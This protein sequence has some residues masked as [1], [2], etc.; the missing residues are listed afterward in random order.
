MQKKQTIAIAVVIVVLLSASVV[1][2]IAMGGNNSHDDRL[3]KTGRLLIYGNADN[4]DYL[5]ENDL[6]MVKDIAGG[7]ATWNKTKNPFADTNYDGVVDQKDVDLLQRFINKESGTMHFV[8]A[9]GEVD[10]ITYPLVKNIGCIHMYP[11]DACIALGLYEDV[12]AVSHNVTT[13]EQWEDKD[14]YPETHEFIDMGTPKKDPEAVLASGVK[15]IINHSET[16]L[17]KLEEAIA[18]AKLDINVVQLNLSLYDPD[19]PDRN[20]SMLML[21]VMFQVEEAAQKYVKFMDNI[22]KEVQKTKL[23]AKTCLASLYPTETSTEVDVTY[24][25]GTMYGELYTLSFINIS[26][27]YHPSSEIM[28]PE[29]EM[30]QVYALNPDVIFY[31]SLSGTNITVQDGQAEFKESADC[32]SKTDAYKNK[33]IY[34]VNYYILGGIYGISQLPLICSY[35]WPD[36]FDSETG[37]KYIQDYYDQFTMYKN[38]DVKELAGAQVYTL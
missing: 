29:L 9:G 31:V 18:A 16:D 15:T 35:I 3:D 25:D 13:N 24:D 7:S 1:A 23:P 26:D 33:M 32:F 12:K 11:I 27:V 34:G 17:S 8:S 38:V 14:R 21:G 10:S 36:E 2:V 28:Y 6:K 22:V 37:W 20:G 5:D 4:D 19:G 30:E